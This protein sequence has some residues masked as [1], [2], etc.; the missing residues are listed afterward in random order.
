MHK[1]LLAV[2]L[3][4]FLTVNANSQTPAASIIRI[5][6]VTR[7][8]GINFR[9][10][11]GGSGMAYIVEG[12]SA[13]LATFDYDN[14]GWIDIY[15]LNGRSL[16]GS[17]PNPKLKN[18]LYRNNGDWTF[19]D[20]TEQAGAGGTGYG[21]GVVAGD[22]DGDGDLDLY[23]NNYG[24]NQLLRNN[25]D[26]TFT[27]V[28]ESAGVGNG[29]KVGAGAVFVDGDNDGDLDLF[30][31]NYVDF[32]Y[33]N[34]VE[35][36]R[37]GKRYY[38]G[39]QY[40]RPV[41]DTYYRNEGNGKF[42]DATEESGIGAIAGPSMGMIAA[43]FDDDG[44]CDVFVCND[45]EPNFLWQNDGKGHFQ[46][47]ALTAG[48]A[49]DFD[50]NENS[51][52]GVDAADYDGDGLL[53]LFT[54]NYQAELPVLR[55]NL[56]NGLFEDTTASSRIPHPLYPHVTW[57]TGFADFDSDGD[58]DIFI[59]CGHFDQVELVD[60]STAHKVRNFLLENN[61]RKFRDV[62]S[63]CGSGMAIVESSRGIA[64]DDLD[65]D[66]DVDI[67]VLNSGALPSILRNDTQS[68]HA[69][70]QI[71]LAQPGMNSMA[72]GAKV[73]VTA[74]GKKRQRQDVVAGRGY[75]SH[76]GTRITFGVPSGTQSAIAEVTWP[77]GHQQQY[78]L[79]LN[80]LNKIQRES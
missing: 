21:L 75:Q 23:V 66:G 67:V 61:N 52:M 32:T 7:E 65:N 48:V 76:F 51:N 64:L 46:E 78:P 50:G 71:E 9:H 10:D 19:T 72:I 79:K 22:Y 14:D 57:G 28:T 59:A 1:I 40:Y 62:S 43:D 41:T 16:K 73:I 37:D 47:V 31:G 17:V 77:D 5:T 45:G 35:I 24:P 6:D 38:A 20:V 29:D 56:G 39:P 3:V 60:D 34:H 63:T 13:G 44:D 68:P 70:C 2:A 4:L 11:H 49:C 12:V 33:E 80:S 54:T 36:I 42:V 8:S 69:W 53:D 55:R 30:V 26:K 58:R 15:L 27:D 25:G 18:A 74:D